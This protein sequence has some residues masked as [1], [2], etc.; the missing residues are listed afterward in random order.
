LKICFQD[1]ELKKKQEIII[2]ETTAR[3]IFCIISERLLGSSENIFHLNSLLQ[4]TIAEVAKEYDYKVVFTQHVSL[5]R[6]FYNN[7]KQ[8]FEEDWSSTPP[9]VNNSKFLKS[10]RWE[11]ELC[12]IAD[13]TICLNKEGYLFSR[14]YYELAEE[15]LALIKNGVSLGQANM[16]LD[17]IKG[18]KR[19][20][21]FKDSDFIFLFVGRLIEQ[22]GITP[23]IHAFKM[24]AAR[25]SNVRLL[26]VGGGEELSKF[27]GL[28]ADMC[29]RISYT[30]Y[31]EKE[32]IDAYYNIANVGV[33]PSVTEQSS[34]VVLEMLSKKL[35]TILSDIEAFDEFRGG[36]NVEKVKTNGN[37]YVYVDLLYKA[38]KHMYEDVLY[39]ER[40]AQSGHQLFLDQYQASTM[41]G[42]T[43]SLY[44]EVA[45]LTLKTIIE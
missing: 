13:K 34:F 33:M 15:R 18:L 2:N 43:Y 4:K 45:D 10:I 11:R 17:Q 20:M 37:G 32:K 26:A 36:V 1:P 6:V 30:G 42:K 7:N 38:M 19:S 27:I 25:T 9:E 3:A 16:S 22:K 8:K 12:A 40:I 44:K 31:I 23:L 29:G 14:Q 35:P 39:R 5:W 24:L 41:A 21:G 28:S